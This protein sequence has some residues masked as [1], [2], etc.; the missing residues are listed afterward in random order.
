MINQSQQWMFMAFGVFALVLLY[1]LS[2]MLT[3]F[4]VSLFLAYLGDPL[5]DKLEER[6]YSRT[7]SVVLVFTCITL[8]LLLTTLLVIPALRSQIVLL[9][10]LWPSLVEWINSTVLPWLQSMTGADFGLNTAKSWL[11]DDLGKAGAVA[12]DV[13]KR[14]L[15]SGMSVF[16]WF[17]NLALIPVVTFYFLRDWDVM[18]ARVTSMVPPRYLSTVSTLT[19]ESDEVLGGFLRG[20]VTVMVVLAIVYCTGLWIS[21]IKLAFLLGL[22]A[23]LVS[24]VP[25]LGFIVGFVLAGIAAL[26]QFGDWV[27]LVY[28]AI[29]FGVGQLLESFVLTPLLVGD[30]IG[31]HPVAV[32]FAVMAGGQLFGFM[33]V[34]LALPVAAVLLVFLRHLHRVYLDSPMYDNGAADGE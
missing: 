32:I 18:V 6:G 28:V 21:G 29:T 33:G 8:I 24:F 30:K 5:A 11:L 1:L 20:Q 22:I 14:A 19:K 12:G 23:G 13:F 15:G 25:Y 2:P 3:P 34:L 7:I 31:L 9:V 27:P 10:K 26:W 4:V 17:G 16:A